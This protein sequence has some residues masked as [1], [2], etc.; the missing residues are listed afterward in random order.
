MHIVTSHAHEGTRG[1][2]W[3]ALF[4]FGKAGC[5]HTPFFWDPSDDECLIKFKEKPEAAESSA[6]GGT[7]EQPVPVRSI[8]GLS[9]VGGVL[10]EGG[11]TGDLCLPRGGRR[12][13]VN[14]FARAWG[15]RA[16]SICARACGGRPSPEQQRIRKKQR[17]AH[18][19]SQNQEGGGGRKRRERARNYIYLSS[20]E[21]SLGPLI[22]RWGGC[23]G[24]RRL[25]GSKGEKGARGERGKENPHRP[26]QERQKEKHD[27][28]DSRR[29]KT[30]LLNF[31]L[32]L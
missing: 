8:I 21:H 13:G 20:R 3:R 12:G 1:E 15:E 24:P 2:G 29:T 19:F 30:R 31:F 6:R 25:L 7:K 17:W 14:G 32:Q 28:I 5:A 10:N 22:C 9:R 4:A 16:L 27:E 18:A 11:G 23:G 26:G